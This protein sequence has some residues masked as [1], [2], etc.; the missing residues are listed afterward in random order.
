M[1]CLYQSGPLH[2]LSVLI[3]DLSS[4]LNL[5]FW[6]YERYCPQIKVGDC[7]RHLNSYV[8]IPTTVVEAFNLNFGKCLS[9]SFSCCEK[10][11][12]QNDF[13]R[14]GALWFAHPSN[15]PSLGEVRAEPQAGTGRQE[16]MPRSWWNA[17]Y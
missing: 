6:Y 5:Q 12:D 7:I 14:K 16:L 2:S 3:P 15:T 11:H 9:Y 10:H 4:A 1:N 17:T 13:G 8:E